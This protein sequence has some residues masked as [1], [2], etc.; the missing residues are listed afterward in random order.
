ML[1]LLKHAANK[2]DHFKPVH[3]DATFP[4]DMQTM[5]ILSFTDYMKALQ[6][7]RI[8]L[9]SSTSSSNYTIPHHIHDANYSQFD[10]SG[11]PHHGQNWQVPFIQ[12]D[13]R[14][15]RY[16]GEEAYQYCHYPK[17]ALA[18]SVPEDPGGSQRATKFRGYLYQRYPQLQNKSLPAFQHADFVQLFES[19]AAVEEYTKHLEY[20]K[21][22]RLRPKLAMAIVFT[23]DDGMDYQYSIR[24]NSTNQNAPEWAGSSPSTARTTPDTNRLFAHFA[25]R[26]GQTCAHLS[27]AIPQSPLQYSCTGQYILNGLLTMQRFLHDWIMVDTGAKDIGMF[28]AEHGVKF[29]PFPSRPYEQEGFFGVL[30]EFMPLFF[31]LGMLYP[32]ASMISYIAEERETGQKEFLKIMSVQEWEIGCSWFCTFS[33]LHFW[34]AI[35]LT[36]VSAQVFVHSEI[37]ILWIFWQSSLTA[38]IVFSSC[39]T[40]LLSAKTKTA[41][42][43]VLAGLLISL[44]GYFVTNAV[45]IEE[46]Y[47]LWQRFF[48]LHPIAAMSYGIQ[49]IGRLEDA[50]VGVTWNSFHSTDSPS[51]FTFLV[52]IQFLL[53]SCLLW[54][55]TSWYF[56]RFT[57]TTHQGCAFGCSFPFCVSYWFPACLKRFPQNPEV[58]QIPIQSKSARIDENIHVETVSD[59]LKQQAR[60]GSSVEIHNLRKVYSNN[61]GSCVYAVNGLNLSLYRGQITALLGHNGKFNKS[62]GLYIS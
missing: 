35:C 19:N 24:V 46:N 3:V 49:E 44:A 34:T 40:S 23:G 53:G 17:L 56:N 55:G 20:G 41:T 1:V 8:C 25:K 7:K 6:A 18:P 16:H 28:V 31:T 5:Q 48:C 11:M 61:I 10:I 4:P 27:S 12:C 52:S 33:A 15:C 45:K 54:T 30:N 43:T 22:P 62:T 21:D 2:R 60:D 42:R 13:S 39:L 59:A 47:I 29:L 36:F 57:S 58:E 14:H 32:C 26:E 50:G 37:T 9:Q 51:G 38:L